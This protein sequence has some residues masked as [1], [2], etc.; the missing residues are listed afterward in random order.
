MVSDFFLEL[1]W[2]LEGYQD[3]QWAG[4]VAVWGQAEAEKLVQPEEEVTSRGLMAA[5]CK[6]AVAKMES[7]HSSVWWY[8]RD[9]TQAE[10]R[11]F[12][13][14]FKEELDMV[15]FWN[16]LPR[17]VSTSSILGFLMTAE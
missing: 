11:A 16:R 4:I 14:G 9:S 7:V 17:E 13:P 12:P 2:I 1:L 8:M 10:T 5:F 3:A 15:K 6:K